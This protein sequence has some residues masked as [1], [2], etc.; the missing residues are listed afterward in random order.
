LNRLFHSKHSI[1]SQ[2]IQHK[3][4]LI[5]LTFHQHL[6]QSSHKTWCL[7]AA[8]GSSHSF[9]GQPYTA[10]TYYFLCCS[11]TNESFGLWLM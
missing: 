6:Y 7:S 3:P 10:D 4:L 5:W 8:S 11:G 2:P 1:S 9:F